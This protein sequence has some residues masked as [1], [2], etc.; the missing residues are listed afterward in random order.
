MPDLGCSARKKKLPHVE[1]GDQKFFIEE[2]ISKERAS[3]ILGLLIIKYKR[4]TF[5]AMNL[6][7]NNIE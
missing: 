1:F 4:F 2:K 5:R 3:S 7:I 6:D